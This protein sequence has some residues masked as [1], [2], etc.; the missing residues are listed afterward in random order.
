LTR[1]SRLGRVIEQ[2]GPALALHG[3]AHHGAF[4]M[5]SVSGIPIHNVALPILQRRQ[6]SHPFAMFEV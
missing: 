6:E 5:K 1:S 3:D 2:H 4:A